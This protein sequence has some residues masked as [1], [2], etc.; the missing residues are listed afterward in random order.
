MAKSNRRVFKGKQYVINTKNFL[1]GDS[2]KTKDRRRVDLFVLS[3]N[4]L[5]TIKRDLVKNPKNKLLYGPL[6]N[7]ANNY[8]NFTNTEDC[9]CKKINQ[10]YQNKNL[11]YLIMGNIIK[12]KNIFD[13]KRNLTLNK[14][15]SLVQQHQIIYLTYI[16]PWKR[17]T[18]IARVLEEE[19]IDA[20][21]ICENY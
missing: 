2:I 6:F 4:H 15:T 16:L 21:K 8:K 19:D 18:Q 20:E 10:N 14:D 12:T 13:L 7:K 9:N 3:K 17:A 1:T 11:K 5:N